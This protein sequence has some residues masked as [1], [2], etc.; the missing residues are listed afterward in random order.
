[1]NLLRF[2]RASIS[3]AVKAASIYLGCQVTCSH[4][5]TGGIL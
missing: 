1:M 4:H 5:P 2:Y 3:H